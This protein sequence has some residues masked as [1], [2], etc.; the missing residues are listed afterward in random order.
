MRRTFTQFVGNL[1]LQW[2]AH[3]KFVGGISKV[4][5]KSFRTQK[6]NLRR[7]NEITKVQFVNYLERR[8]LQIHQIAGGVEVILALCDFSLSKA[9]L[10]NPLLTVHVKKVFVVRFASLRK[11]A[12][13]IKWIS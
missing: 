5:A 12:L 10:L 13:D 3:H 1:I 7:S 6:K 9:I 4:F 8:R 11:M 2:K